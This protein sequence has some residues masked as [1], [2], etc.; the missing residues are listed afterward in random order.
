MEPTIYKPSIYKGAGIYKSGAE[1]GGGGNLPV[2]G[3]MLYRG[4]FTS[5][6]IKKSIKQD[7]VFEFN[8]TF[9]F[10][11]YL[12]TGYNT[13]VLTVN[14]FPFSR[15]NDVEIKIDLSCSFERNSYV[16]CGS[17]YDSWW[18]GPTINLDKDENGIYLLVVNPVIN[19]SDWARN[20]LRY[21]IDLQPNT[22]Y[23]I[24]I[25]HVKNTDKLELYV[26]ENYC[27]VA[28]GEGIGVYYGNIDKYGIGGINN[29]SYSFMYNT[30][31][32][33]IKSTSYIKING[34]F[35]KRP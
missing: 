13:D 17:M 26:D 15:V 8:D 29:N 1:G 12:R 27:G 33:Y 35:L 2:N 25:K 28:D 14:N 11:P 5:D 31:G 20:A 16:L 10:V 6:A 19:Q 21:Y 18:R 4:Y 22:E 9:K 23:S 32:N 30:S 3:G 24:I 34:E 7:N